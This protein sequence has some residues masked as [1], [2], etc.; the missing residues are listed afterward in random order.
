MLQKVQTV[1]A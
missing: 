1:V